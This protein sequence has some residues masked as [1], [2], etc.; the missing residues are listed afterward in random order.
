MAALIDVP[1]A[2]FRLMYQQK[3][4]T[5]DLTPYATGIV[6]VDHL[7]GE[8][9]E[10]EI[11]L[12]DSDHRWIDAWYPN[13]GDQLTFQIGFK[14]G[15]LTNAGAFDIDEIEIELLPTT[16]RI[17]ALSAGIMKSI[18]TRRGRSYED[19]T[20]EAIANDV[21]K[22]NRLEVVGKIDTVKIDRVSQWQ[23]RDVEFLTRLAGEY[24]YVF[25]IQGI[26]LAFSKRADLRTAAAVQTLDLKQLANGRFMDKIRDVYTNADLT[27]HDSKT[28]KTVSGKATDKQ[29][30]S[31]DTLRL[32]GRATTKATADAK[33]AAAL[34]QHNMQRTTGSLS[35]WGNPGLCAGV[36]VALTGIGKLNGTYLIETSRHKLDKSRG[37]DTELELKRV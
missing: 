36:N 26:K 8:S 11:T 29:A 34:E 32:H 6:W 27:Y 33:A 12:E 5:A 35:L 24:G 20:L 9:D 3:D 2:D 17:R 4:I 21:A 13:K 18:R 14:G 10:L 19:T 1:N 22:R 16:V 28:K 23:E 31:A 15:V 37:Y 7:D 25:K 30:A